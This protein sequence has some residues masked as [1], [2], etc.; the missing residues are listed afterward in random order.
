MKQTQQ[1]FFLQYQSNWILDDSRLKILEKSR[2]VGMTIATAY[3]AVRRHVSKKNNYDT[4]IASRDELQA[5]LFVDDCKKFSKILAPACDFFGNRLIFE[6]KFDALSS[7]KFSNGTAINSLSSSVDSQAG[8]RGSRILDEFALHRDQKSLYATTLPGITWGGRL[9]I[10]STHR[11][12]NN[13]FNKLICEV[14]DC[15]NPKNFSYHRVTLQ[16]A[17]E[18]G[19]LEKLKSKLPDDDERVHM[20]NG[21]YFDFVKNSCPD[22][23]SFLQEY[24]CVPAD[25]R[26]AFIASD[27]V[28]NCEYEF[29]E[30]NWE[31]SDFSSKTNECFLGI[32]IG[33][34]NDLTV[35]WLLERGKNVLLTRKVLC[36]Q[37]ETF[38]AQEK[39]LQKFFA[40]RNL[41][42]ICIDQTGIGRQFYERASDNFGKYRVEGIT[43]TYAVKE[44]L[45]YQLRTAF[46]NREIKIP[47]DD[48][49]RAD[50]RS[51]RRETTLAGNIR[52]AGDRGRNGHADR[53]WA[54]ALAIHAAG[55]GGPRSA[56]C[57]ENVERLKVRKFL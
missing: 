30:Q 27:M 35:F 1:S 15:G 10:L 32:D 22:E 3:S 19:F 57:F 34:T 17:L 13:F 39:E 55:T 29:N 52:F 8:K 46:E 56:V 53:F 43:F 49:I 9:E 38:S 48:F 44:Q 41:R 24:M 25:D 36:M 5:K 26:S 18:Q 50:L 51:I 23:E 47:S 40:V 45:A 37:N 11:G 20:S 12:S 54:L 14:R 6:E 2:Q 31:L 21:E 28:T 16:D 7:L 42:R 4:W 33:R